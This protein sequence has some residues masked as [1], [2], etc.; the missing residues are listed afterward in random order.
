MLL[1]ERSNVREIAAKVKKFLRRCILQ[2]NPPMQQGIVVS[3]EQA[4]EPKF[5]VQ[6]RPVI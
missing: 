4:V 1:K 3:H 2:E 5:V 6:L